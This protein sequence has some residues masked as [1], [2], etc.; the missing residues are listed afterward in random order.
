MGTFL[1]CAMVLTLA[2]VNGW[3]FSVGGAAGFTIAGTIGEDFED[4]K[5]A[6]ADFLSSYYAT[7]ATVESRLG[8]IW[9]AGVFLTADVN[10]RVAIQ[11]E[12]WYAQT[13]SGMEATLT[14]YS[15]GL[16]YRWIYRTLELAIPVKVRFRLP[17]PGDF[18]HGSAE[19]G[20]YA[21]PVVTYLLD[22]PPRLE[23][24]ADGGDSET[25]DWGTE[26]DFLRFALGA[27][28]GVDARR[29]FENGFFLGLDAR[30]AWTFTSFDNFPGGFRNDTRVPYVR[31]AVQAGTRL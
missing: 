21:G 23:I 26:M 8:A 25:I 30:F 3:D 11:P 6:E 10:S 18:G 20:L 27:V 5:A 1:V 22:P 4:L 31:L 29:Y 24:K 2:P 14:G 7:D 9:S 12:L 19:M 15:G 16:N 28:V 13:K 17:G